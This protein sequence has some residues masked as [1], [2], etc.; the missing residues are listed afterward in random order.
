GGIDSSAIAGV[1]A[2]ATATEPNVLRAFNVSYP[3]LPAADE[4]HYARQVADACGIPLTTVPSVGRSVDAY[5]RA[6]RLLRD[7]APGGVGAIEL[8]FYETIAA[9]GCDLVLDGTG[10]DE[11][12]T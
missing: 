1:A 8:P 6:P 4:T 10:A 11:W 12:F 7:M 9:D 5:L 2:N 3:G